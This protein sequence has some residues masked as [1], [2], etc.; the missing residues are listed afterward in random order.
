[1]QK[2]C[3]KC[4]EVFENAEENFYKSSK[5][6]SGFNSWCK[7]CES[8]KNSIKNKS[9]EIVKAAYIRNKIFR[10]KAKAIIKPLLESKTCSHC[11]EEKEII[12]FKTRPVNKDGY[13]NQCKKCEYEICT[14]SRQ[15]YVLKNWAKRL[16]LDAKAHSKYDFDI[17]E[18]FVSE[19][20]EKQNGKCF[21]FNVDL[22]PSNIA[23]YPWQPSLD[24][25][26]RDKGYT[27]D[28]VVLACYSANIGRNTSDKETF[29]AFVIDLK[30]ALNDKNKI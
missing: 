24:R 8:I 4:K 6:K 9:E 3:S 16:F 14:D 18:Q 28:N 29:E 7:K 21:W 13:A 19:L 1:M 22:K 25:L 23:K 12:H 26:D 27:K 15:A 11:N 10:E 5:L 17:D 20:Y 2:Q 30:K